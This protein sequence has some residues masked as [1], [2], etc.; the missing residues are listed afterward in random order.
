MMW[1]ESRMQKLGFCLA[2]RTAWISTSSE[3]RKTPK[4]EGFGRSNELV[5]KTPETEIVT[6]PKCVKV[7]LSRRMIGQGSEILN[8]V[9]DG[10]ELG[11]S[12]DDFRRVY[13]FRNNG[14]RRTQCH[15]QAGV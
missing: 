10:S 2:W 15:A 13:Y 12:S 4:Q 9:V 11:R 6:R 7:N 8:V 14:W 3:R 1:R 5:K